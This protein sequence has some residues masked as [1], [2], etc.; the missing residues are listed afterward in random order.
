MIRYTCNRCG[1]KTDYPTN[2][3]KHLNSKT[4]CQ[5]VL[6]DI[7]RALV[8]DEYFGK[9]DY[10]Y[11][12][13]ICK[14]KYKTKETV[15]VHKL[16]SHKPRQR[17]QL[18]ITTTTHST[19]PDTPC[20]A[21]LK[22]MRA[23][24]VGAPLRLRL[25]VQRPR[26]CSSTLGH[27]PVVVESESN[28]MLQQIVDLLQTLVNKDRNP[29]VNLT[30]TCINNGVINVNSRYNAFLKENLEY[31]S[32]EYI[33]KCAKRL[34]NG[35]VDFI[36]TIRFNPDH[37]ENMNVRMHVKR[38]KT[39]YVYIND[40]WEICDAKWTLEEMII[41]GARIIYQKFLTNSDQEKLME[42]G[43]SE[44]LINTWLLSVLPKDNDKVMNKLSKRLYAVILNNQNVLLVEQPETSDIQNVMLPR[45]GT[46]N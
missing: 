3:K 43:S 21:Q 9:N 12:C 24:P 2:F 15:R 30:Q 18:S 41:H 37:P 5:P 4:V 31:I 8:L 17:W 19:A 42:E 46:I 32:D 26:R 34:D 6:N 27:K 38:D 33:M 16:R 28:M 29:T 20:L 45:K 36:K 40:R 1:Y 14:R 39:L 10:L 23:T 25:P 35:L 44:A 22:Y 7:D 13:D 11:E